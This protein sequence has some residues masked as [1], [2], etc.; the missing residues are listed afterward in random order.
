MQEAEAGTVG[1]RSGGGLNGSMGAVE[2]DGR[3]G[4]I[5]ADDGLGRRVPGGASGGNPG[6]HGRGEPRSGGD[7]DRGREEFVV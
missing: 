4:A 2:E 1:D 5:E 7:A 3:G 6:H